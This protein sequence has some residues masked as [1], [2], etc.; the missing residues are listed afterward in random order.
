MR[1]FPAGFTAAKN[2]LTGAAP[3]WILKLTAGGVDYYLA[4]GVVSIAGW[5]GGI[6][7]RAWIKSWGQLREQISGSTS[8][9][10]VA[11][12]PVSCIVDPD[13]SPHIATLATT[14]ELE[15]SP[16]TLYL[17]FRGLDAVTD[18]PQAM[19]SGYVRDV[20]LPDE[21]TVELSIEDAT[22]RLQGSVGTAIT[23]AMYPDADP[24]DIG[25]MIP[26]VYGAVKKL[27]ALAVSAG[28]QTS[29]PVN[30]GSTATSM[31]V[32][33]AYG[34]SVGDTVQVD[35]ELLL[36]TAI[37]GDTLTVTRGYNATIPTTHLKGAVVWESR[38]SFAYL[39][40]DHP[41]DSIDKVFGRVGEAEVDITAIAAV[42]TGQAGN[43]HASYPGKAVVTI[44]GYITVSQAVTLMVAD[45]LSISDT[46]AVLDQLLINDGL[47]ISDLLTVNDGV[48]VYD[49][50]TIA[51]LL[52]VLDGIG[53]SNGT[54]SVSDTIGLSDG[55][56][57][58]DTIAVSDGI[59]VSEP[60][61]THTRSVITTTVRPDTATVTS[62][63]T[64]TSPN[65]YGYNTIN[66]QNGGTGTLFAST[67]ANIRF[68]ATAPAGI[69]G[70]PIRMR[71]AGLCKVDGTYGPCTFGMVIGG[72]TVAQVT[73]YHDGIVRKTG[74]YNIGA[75]ST[76]YASNTW[77]FAASTGFAIS[78]EIWFEIEY[79][80]STESS[81][82]GV[83]KG[84]TVSKSGAA[85]KSGTVSKTGAASFSGNV[86]KSG[87]V[88]RSGSVDRSGSI[89]KTG[90]V[91][92]GGAV[93]RAGAV[94]RSGAVSKTGQVSLSGSVELSGNS[95]ANT[96][97]GDTVMV[98][99]TRSLTVPQVMDDLLA[100]AGSWPAVSVR[101]SLPG[102]VAINGAITEQRR[103]VEWLDVIAWEC[104]SWFRMLP[105]GPALLVRPDAPTSVKAIPAIRLHSDGRRAV[106]RRKIDLEDV[107]TRIDLLYDRDY[108]Q[109]AND[110]TAF[111]G[112]VSAESASGL[113]SYGRRE[114][115][116]LFRC[117][118]VTT[119]AHAEMLRDFYLAWHALRRWMIEVEVFLDHSELEFGDAV[120]LTALA[121]EV[122]TIVDAAIRPGDV[123]NCD[124]LALTIIV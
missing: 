37:S 101:G 50:M 20:S 111:A 121:G 75:W 97:V 123:D 124:T 26:I 115:P 35:D 30:L 33:D 117:N 109:Y 84:G 3:I 55:I 21:T 46:I 87:T 22:T 64:I 57:V 25:K 112:A 7:T 29:L 54:I 43:A 104:R 41:V 56:T 95:V 89:S 85:S 102:T 82:A 108:Q 119:A 62:G 77:A 13:A 9:I 40:A 72:V 120:T 100:R 106:A 11:D 98:N 38:S 103:A 14:Y 45:G 1:S 16:C 65:D 70:T 93:D 58:S 81:A 94:D 12:I 91:A 39:V 110:A 18:P 118:F 66:G 47:T 92:R 34:L 51:D 48:G 5:N 10:R 4:D 49:G 24:D 23:R 83:S 53:V 71:V 42:Y 2:T 36:I 28:V 60:G 69:S 31:R 44:P 74:W 73:M 15:A 67:G 107:I 6:T 80:P 96:L 122:G 8:E 32:S 59:Y 88:T 116:E 113:A 78:S 27:P 114:R 61:H 76:V 105:A 17:W 63:S 68:F 99:V 90:T 52:A 86:A 79:D 19:F